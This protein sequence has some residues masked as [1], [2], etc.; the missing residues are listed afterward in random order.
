MRQERELCVRRLRSDGFE[1]SDALAERIATTEG[2]QEGALDAEKRAYEAVD[3]ARAKYEAAGKVD[4]LF[5]AANTAALALTELLGRT[6]EFRVL[7]ERAANARRAQGLSDVEQHAS[8]AHKAAGEF[9]TKM[10]T[11]SG[12]A[13]RASEAARIAAGV[14]DGLKAKAHEIDDLRQT[15]ESLAR[16]QLALAGADELARVLKGKTILVGKAKGALNSASQRHATLVTTKTTQELAAKQARD[17]ATT[18]AGLNLELA[19]VDAALKEA[20]RFERAQENLEKAGSKVAHLEL[21]LKKKAEIAVDAKAL[22]DRAEATLAEAQA[23]HLAAKLAPG[24]ACPVCGSLEHPAPATGKIENQGRDQARRDAHEALETA[25]G[26]RDAAAAEAAGA[27]GAKEVLEKDVATLAQPAQSAA[28][29][30][31]RKATVNARI[32]ELG[33]EIDVAAAERLAEETGK[34]T[35]TAEGVKE[36]ARSEHERLGQDEALARGQYENALST[37]PEEYR[38]PKVLQE[39]VDRTNADIEARQGALK[40]AQDE[41]RRTHENEIG[42]Q[43][44]A[45]AART[46]FQQAADRRDQ[47]RVAFERRLV[48]AGMSEE[49]YQ[50]FKLNVPTIAADAQ[51]VDEYKTSVEVARKREADARAAT[52]GLEHQDVAP[53]AVALQT[54]EGAAKDA[55]N[56]RATVD[57]RLGQLRGLRDSIAE[58]LRNVEE[59]EKRS[60][61]LREL[62]RLFNA[63]NV[64]K[65]DLETYAIGAMFDYVLEAANLRLGPMT[66]GRYTFERE[67]IEATGGRSRRGLGIWVF[68]V[69]TGKARSPSTLSGGE[70]FI[71]AL[72][73]AL[74]LSDVV[75][76]V[77]GK[78]RLETIFIDEGFGSLD[79][80]NNSGTLDQV[81]QVLT[82]LV[83]QRRAVGLISHVR[84]VQEAIPNGFYVRKEL[85]GSRIEARGAAA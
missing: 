73:L 76:S 34:A 20:E 70:T 80:E 49:L 79:T 45:E 44:D 10:H 48:E 30:S 31:E 29:L 14:L 78:V 40:A 57:T 15:S 5:Q 65:L 36:T 28:I 9:E 41:E 60:A 77:N 46:A 17:K 3:G 63:E 62:A 82:N 22:F 61:P 7:E 38:D 68:D 72:A 53:F 64:M 83:S 18:R 8:D 50:S 26:V 24:E 32:A 42:A 37:I 43:K 59:T 67:M 51:A 84:L 25:V 2:E 19:R 75:E 1:S 27:K 11:A 21:V 39:A 55:T 33:P 69:H 12:A 71:A 16:H 47:A 35:V 74:G 54:A 58:T 13:A 85:R 4:G 23:L 6:E 56:L 81:L 52:F 66:N